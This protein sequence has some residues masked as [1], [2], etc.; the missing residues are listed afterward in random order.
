MNSPLD[1]ERVTLVVDIE[2]CSGYGGASS[3]VCLVSIPTSFP[4]YLQLTGLVGC[5]PNQHPMICVSAD[6]THSEPSFSLCWLMC[7]FA[8]SANS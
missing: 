6:Q 4:V 1:T 3:A 8:H 2:I 5:G 7:D